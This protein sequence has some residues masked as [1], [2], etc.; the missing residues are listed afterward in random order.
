MVRINSTPGGGSA[1][2][3]EE[4]KA[5]SSGGYPAAGRK[6]TTAVATFTG[7]IDLHKSSYE[8]LRLA[9][10]YTRTRQEICLANGFHSD[11]DDSEGDE[12]EGRLYT[13]NYHHANGQLRYTKTYQNIAAKTLPSG[14]YLPPAERLVE[15]K[16]FSPEGV[17]MLEVS[18]VLGQ[19][20]LFRKHYHHNGRPKSE[21]LFYVED[22]RTM[23]CRKAG[24]WRTYW[25]TDSIASEVQYDGNGQRHSFCKRYNRDGTIEWCKDY[26]KDYQER[27][28]KSTFGETKD[29]TA[30]TSSEDAAQILGFP[31]GRL[32]R[33]SHEV[34]REYRRQCNLLHPD[35]SDAPDAAERFEEATR[36]KDLLLRM[37]EGSQMPGAP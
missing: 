9:K 32:P 8:E 31:A 24:T 2:E 7:V 1:A 5:V 35:K 13:E 36:A 29:R 17:C 20:Y 22:D 19:P 25:D 18:F 26:T 37:F 21:K 34:N 14:E 6:E 23:K 4:P 28:H 10:V 30:I 11:D 15:E 12:D 27:I 3:A 16:H 33:S